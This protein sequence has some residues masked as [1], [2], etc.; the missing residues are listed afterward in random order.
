MQQRNFNAVN[1]FDFFIKHTIS[2]GQVNVSALDGHHI[3]DICEIYVN[4]SGDVSFMVEN[5]VYPVK[6]GEAIITRPHEYHHCIYHSNTEHDHYWILFSS[7]GNEDLLKSFFERKLGEGNHIIPRDGEALIELCENLHANSDD[8]LARMIDFWRLIKL[9]DDGAV[10]ISGDGRKIHLKL[11]KTL[12][13]I[14]EHLTAEITVS[15]LADNAHVSINT[16]ERWFNDELQMSPKEFIMHKRL[17][18]AA[19]LLRNNRNVQDAGLA[20]G[21]NDSSYFIKKFKQY[22]G[23]TPCKYSKAFAKGGLNN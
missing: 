6:R 9:L 13:F 18:T 15:D 8:E 21:F 20:S 10:G 1:D 17:N 14:Q 3:H 2:K 19:T 7:N 5:N 11:Q 16:L 22:Y 12:E 4:L 23:T